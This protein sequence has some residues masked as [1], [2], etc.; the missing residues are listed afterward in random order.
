MNRLDNIVHD[1]MVENNNK[2]TRGIEDISKVAAKRIVQISNVKNLLK[3][4]EDHDK[5]I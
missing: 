2:L 1:Q 4:E 5:D 3:K